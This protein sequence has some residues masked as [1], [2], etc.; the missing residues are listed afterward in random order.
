MSCQNTATSSMNPCLSSIASS[1]RNVTI[2][3][4][5]NTNNAEL[6]FKVSE[7]AK[8]QDLVSLIKEELKSQNRSVCDDWTFEVRFAKKNG[9]PKSDLP[10][11]ITLFEKKYN[12][13]KLWNNHKFWRIAVILGSS[14]WERRRTRIAA[15]WEPR[16]AVPLETISI[17]ATVSFRTKDSRQTKKSRKKAGWRN[18]FVGAPSRNLLFKFDVWNNIY[19]KCRFFVELP[20]TTYL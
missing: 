20:Y 10:G 7:E 9:K 18:S 12:C 3:F 6:A 4:N 13:L 14:L 11:I 15:I 19:V 2:F 17:S 16:D 1:Y 8:I 5:C